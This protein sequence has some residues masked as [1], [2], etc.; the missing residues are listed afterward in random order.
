MLSTRPNLRCYFL[1]TDRQY[2]T[3]IFNAVRTLT[4][5][6]LKA[7]NKIRTFTCIPTAVILRMQA[8]VNTP[9]KQTARIGRFSH[10]DRKWRQFWSPWGWRQLLGYCDTKISLL[11]FLH[12]PRL[13][14]STV[15]LQRIALISKSSYPSL[16]GRMSDESFSVLT[17]QSVCVCV[18]L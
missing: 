17:F 4:S 18:K 8:N 11:A 15:L 3:A 5:M 2:V 13:I 12:L 10:T 9:C 16:S 1:W 7:L 6:H 14:R